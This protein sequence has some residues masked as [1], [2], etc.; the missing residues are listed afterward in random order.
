MT[1]AKPLVS[2]LGLNLGFGKKAIVGTTTTK[3]T[4]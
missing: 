2:F 3:P 4:K 1:G